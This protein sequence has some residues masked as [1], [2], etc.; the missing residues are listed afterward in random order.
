MDGTEQLAIVNA[1]VWTGSP[2][3]PW[4]DAVLIRGASVAL[5]G[6][7]A[8]V[9]KQCTRSCHRIDARGMLV[10]PH[11]KD[12]RPELSDGALAKAVQLSLHGS[13]AEELNLLEAGAPA[14][15]VMFDRDITRADPV[16][17]GIAR[18]VLVMVAGRVLLDRAGLL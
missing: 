15:L 9:R 7:S 17:S 8:E 3:R 10:V 6:S 5:V 12:T 14:D 1:R 18:V 2:R 13:V 4:A 16:D 11:W